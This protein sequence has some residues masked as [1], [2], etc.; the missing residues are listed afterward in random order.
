MH[1]EIITCN[2]WRDDVDNNDKKKKK[3]CHPS[4]RFNTLAKWLA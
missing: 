2:G 1:Y 4:A 3:T